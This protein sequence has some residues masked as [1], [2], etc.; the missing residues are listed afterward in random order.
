MLV[1]RYHMEKK[2]TYYNQR[3]NKATQKYQQEKLSQVRFWVKKEEKVAIQEEAQAHGMS[4]KKF[5]SQAINMMVEKQ[6]VSYSEDEEKSDE[7]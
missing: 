6:L 3:Q 2:K 4:M 5:I 1:M 7:S